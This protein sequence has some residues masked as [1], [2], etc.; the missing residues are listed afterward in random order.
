M[1]TKLT[2]RLEDKLIQNAKKAARSRG[3]S[4]SRMVADYFRTIPALSEKG[5]HASPVLLEISGILPAK[6]DKGKL[7]KNYKKH[8]EE[9]YR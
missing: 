4:V 6:A 7:L 3:I 1:G 9:K 8:L 5:F 2:L